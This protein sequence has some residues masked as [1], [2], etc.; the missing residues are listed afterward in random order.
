VPSSEP[1][2][3]PP[4]ETASSIGQQLEA[5]TLRDAQKAAKASTSSPDACT[6][7]N[8]S[9]NPVEQ[10]RTDGG[11]V[12]RKLSETAEKCNLSSP[13]KSALRE[14]RT[15][16]LGLITEPAEQQ[17]AANSRLLPESSS[18]SAE[19]QTSETKTL[20]QAGKG[21]TAG[22][23]SQVTQENDEGPSLGELFN[24]PLEYEVTAVRSV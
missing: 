7:K 13:S 18:A 21:R 1:N 14:K 17:G 2:L 3:C 20:N 24:T 5:L 15:G 9:G 6:H 11:G 10:L 23:G 8:I 12:Q 19:M 4:K 22:G 16:E